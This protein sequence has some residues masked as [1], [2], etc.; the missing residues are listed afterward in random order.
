MSAF[1][2]RRVSSTF[3][4]HSPLILLHLQSHFI[5][6]K[7]RSKF[8]HKHFFPSSLHWAIKAWTKW[9][10]WNFNLRFNITKSDDDNQRNSLFLII[11]L[12]LPSSNCWKNIVHPIIIYTR[13]YTLSFFH[14][15][16]RR[17]KVIDNYSLVG[18]FTAST[19][20]NSLLRFSF[21]LAF[22][23]LMIIKTIE[24]LLFMWLCYTCKLSG[25]N[26]YL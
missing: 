3:R 16:W 26:S 13:N 15:K 14:N 4:F 18:Y 12:L 8:A 1:V 24:R 20:C 25:V 6:T 11:F 5:S 10:R 19:C 22:F 21:V 17:K 23:A 7:N 9:C 2:F